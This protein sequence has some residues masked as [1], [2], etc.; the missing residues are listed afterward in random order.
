MSKTKLSEP[1]NPKTEVTREDIAKL[2]GA[3]LAKVHFVTNRKKWGFPEIIRKGYQGKNIYS[4]SA[5][6]IWLENNDLKAMKFYKQD[7]APAKDHKQTEK[8]INSTAIVQLQIGIK[9]HPFKGRGQSVKVHVEE[10]N[11]YEK[12]RP[13]LTRFSNS[14]AGY[15]SHYVGNGLE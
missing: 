9:P 10:R 3:S 12:P 8:A 2:A 7:R 14:G 6:T 5:V 1:I 4:L 15:I 13:Q 11:E